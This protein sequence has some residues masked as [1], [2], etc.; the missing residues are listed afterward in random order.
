[1]QVAWRHG[2][3]VLHREFKVQEEA[4]AFYEALGSMARKRLTHQ[5]RELAVSGVGSSGWPLEWVPDHPS[6]YRRLEDY[7]C[8][9][10]M[11]RLGGLGHRARVK[12]DASMVDAAH[13]RAERCKHTKIP[14]CIVNPN[15]PDVRYVIL[16]ELMHHQLN[17]LGCPALVCPQL[18]WEGEHLRLGSATVPEDSWLRQVDLGADPQCVP[19][20]VTS[21][22]ELIQHARF[23]PFLMDTF[24]CG[25]EKARDRFCRSLILGHCDLPYCHQ[26]DPAPIRC[27]MLVRLCYA[28]LVRLRPAV[29]CL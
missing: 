18:H 16:H 22:W 27:V 2:S 17:E 4:A 23:N 14:L 5:G 21:L 26:T 3:K 28:M 1:M 19:N 6:S 24:G 12:L 9:E 8:E 25:A 15:T 11:A 10:D 13:G 29:L 20:L 7:L